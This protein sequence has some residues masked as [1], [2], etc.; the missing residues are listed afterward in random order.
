MAIFAM[1]ELFRLSSGFMNSMGGVGINSYACGGGTSRFW[2]VFIAKY[3][4][5]G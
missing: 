1:V 4:V 2:I 5:I 3:R